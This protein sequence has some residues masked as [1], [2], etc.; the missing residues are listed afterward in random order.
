MP[1]WAS[2]SRVP[3]S[4]GLSAGVFLCCGLSAG[5]SSGVN[6]V[7]GNLPLIITL[8]QCP[9]GHP[10]ECRYLH[11]RLGC[12][13]RSGS[14]LPRFALGKRGSFDLLRRGKRVVGRR[15]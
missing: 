7:I 2:N 12:D 1:L 8:R 3:R 6:N 10:H 14:W 5:L 9:G 11:C 13:Y 4:P 15:W